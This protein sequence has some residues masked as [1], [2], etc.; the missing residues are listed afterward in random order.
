[1]V[2]AIKLQLTMTSSSS[3]FAQDLGLASILLPHGLHYG[4]RMTPTITFGWIGLEV[5]LIVSL[6][7]SLHPILI[8]A[9]ATFILLN[10]LGPTLG[11]SI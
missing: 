4:S 5:W 1:M 8:I 11:L 2:D 10:T 6:P 3:N 7:Q 9:I